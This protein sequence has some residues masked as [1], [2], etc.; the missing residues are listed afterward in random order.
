MTG[1][2]GKKN[3]TM[4]AQHIPSCF[5]CQVVWRKHVVTTLTEIPFWL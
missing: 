5:P 3:P 2:L 4:I 1:M